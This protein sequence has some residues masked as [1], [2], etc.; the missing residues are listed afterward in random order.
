MRAT[1]RTEGN[2]L[3]AVVAIDQLG[4]GCTHPERV[5]KG[6]SYRSRRRG[7]LAAHIS[8][9]GVTYDLEQEPKGD[10]G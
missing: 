1:R 7:T 5:I 4:R 10:N 9:G 3:S 6:I 8:L 2:V